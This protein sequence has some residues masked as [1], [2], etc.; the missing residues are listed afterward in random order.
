[1]AKG[2]KQIVKKRSPVPEKNIKAQAGNYNWMIAVSLV[3]TIIALFPVLTAG[4]VNWDDPDYVTKNEIIKSIGNLKEFFTV[5]VQGNY[6]PL[7]MLTLAMNYSFSKLD[8]TSY[9]LVNL[10]FHLANVVLVFYFVLKL[11]GKK[12][13]LAFITAILFG[14]HP[15]HVESVAWISERKDVLYTFF[16]LL[17]LI[18][19]LKFIEKKKLSQFL[20]VIL[21]FFLSLLSKPAAVIFPLVL[22]AIDLYYSRLKNTK[23]VL[24][25]LPFFLLALVFGLITMKTQAGSGAVSLAGMFPVHFRVFFGFYGIMMYIVKTV[26]PL[27]LCTFYPFPAINSALPVEYYVALLFALGLIALIFIFRKK[28]KLIAFSLLFYIINLLLVLQFLPVGSAVIADRYSYI[29][30]LGIFIIPAYF[31]QKITDK[32]KGTPPLSLIIPSAVVIAVLTFLSIQ[33]SGTWKSS[34]TLW[35]RAIEV[36]PSSRALTFRGQIYKREKNYEK[37]KELFTKAIRLNKA[38]TE[39]LV[40]RGNI[41]FNTGKYDSAI[42]DYTSALRF[43]TTERRAIENRG[44]AYGLTGKYDLSLKDLN[45]IIRL[46]PGS[47]TAYANRALLF[48][49]TGRHREAIADYL[50][51]I[52]NAPEAKNDDIWNA[53]GVSYQALNEN[54]KA[55]E[56]FS[57]A[58]QINGAGDYYFNRS[59]SY[60][61]KGDK[62]QAMNDAGQA[63]KSGYKVDNEYLNKLR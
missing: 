49:T 13:W 56:S 29:P 6:H 39:A 26:F 34:T 25:K 45:T 40:D 24:E 21:F 59:H 41:Y 42:A 58:I 50:L 31:F 8:A 22:V 57:K 32:N 35:D 17:G 47:K 14:I 52:K 18:W 16:F 15:L 44:A 60:F 54:D 10:L 19:Y 7:T 28:E 2:K 33:Q 4:F 61:Y 3:L 63:M 37:A 62:K 51:Q 53:T 1:M 36:Q 27:G 38:E 5:P 20:T 9:H 12:P 43:D 23:A 55:I 11:T 30:L 48:Q 46:E